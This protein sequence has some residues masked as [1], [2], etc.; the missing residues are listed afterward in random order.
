MAVLMAK[1]T[2]KRGDSG[3]A[4]GRERRGVVPVR[5]SVA[6]A[7]VSGWDDLMRG[8]IRVPWVGTLLFLPMCLVGWVLSLAFFRTFSKV[9]IPE[10]RERGNNLLW[11]ALGL[12]GWL[13][14]VCLGKA[15]TGRLVG[16]RVYVWAHECTHLV[17]TLLSGGRARLERVGRDGGSMLTDRTNLLIVLSPYF[18]PLL[19]VLVVML[20]PLVGWGAE[21]Y[22][23]GTE[24]P[25]RL[26]GLLY[27]LIGFTLGHHYTFTAYVL[28][29]GQSDLEHYGRM[30]SL[31]VIWVMNVLVLTVVLLMLPRTAPFGV[32]WG[33]LVESFGVVSDVLVPWMERVFQTVSGWL[34]SR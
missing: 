22:G 1:R 3:M 11:M 26:D 13:M 25:V 6:R 20:A 33:E 18:Y 30:F 7:T 28:P 23:G 27:G 17:W 14:V 24:W 2:S 5:L 32:Y 34:V 10:I 19:T 21:R 9:L 31:A 4:R 12:L 8:R 29:K 15:V 16:L